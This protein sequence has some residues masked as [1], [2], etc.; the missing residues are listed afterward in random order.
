MLGARRLLVEA[1]VELSIT[2]TLHITEGTT[3]EQALG[4]FRKTLGY[5]FQDLNNAWHADVFVEKV[6]VNPYPPT[7]TEGETDGTD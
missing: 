1:K 6:T 2:T 7:T 3:D 5:D 4:S